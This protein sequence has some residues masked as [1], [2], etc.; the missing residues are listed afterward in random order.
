MKDKIK[1]ETFEELKSSYSNKE[2]K[3]SQKKEFEDFI[4]ILQKN[5]K[6]MKIKTDKRKR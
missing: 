1:F 3:E 5:R 4:K 6:E 2:A